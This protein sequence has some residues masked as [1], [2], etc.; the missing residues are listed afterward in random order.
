MS[1]YKVIA[2]TVGGLNNK[3]YESGDVVTADCFPVGH[4]EELVTKK[5]LTRVTDSEIATDQVEAKAREE[6]L[7]E[8]EN[9]IKAA[10]SEKLRASQ[11]E[12]NNDESAKQTITKADDTTPVQVASVI[13]SMNV[14]VA[15]NFAEE[16]TSHDKK[17]TQK[18]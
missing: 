2:L 1:K 13:S 16:K 11:P 15:A 5:F 6:K 10:E 12:Q 17:G 7:K 9:A 18:K 14:E 8:E 4:A 3:I